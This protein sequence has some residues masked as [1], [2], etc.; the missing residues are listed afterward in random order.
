MSSFN[1]V[2]PSGTMTAVVGPNG[3]GKSTVMKSLVGIVKPKYGSIEFFGS[4]FKEQY[5]RIAYVPQRINVESFFPMRVKDV[6]AQGLHTELKWYQ[7]MSKEHRRRVH[8]ALEQVNMVEFGDHQFSEISGGLFQRM[9]VARALVQRPEFLILDE[10]FNGVDI[11]TLE[12]LMKI[13]R[14][15]VKNGSTVAMVHH[16]LITVKDY[17]DRVIIMNRTAIAEGNVDDALT[18]ENVCRAY[19]VELE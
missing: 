13:F 9:F 14:E 8:G 16:D 18:R 5:R 15:L 17:F 1:A 3:A 10:P 2:F 6:V 19:G 11:P 4:T 12:I 7:L